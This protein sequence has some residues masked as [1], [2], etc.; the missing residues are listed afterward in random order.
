[1]YKSRR[2]FINKSG[3]II[4]GSGMIS[5]VPMGNVFAGKKI[6]GA[7]DKVTVGLVGCK[8]MGFANLQNFLKQEGV[9]CAALCDVDQNVLDQRASE[10]EKK[11]KQ[12][13]VK[14]NDYRKVIDDK[15]IDVVIVGTPDHWH[16][17]P[18][19][20]A[21]EAGKDVYCEKPLANTIQELDIMVKAVR[22]YDRIVQ[23]GQWQR[24]GPH[25]RAAMDFVFSGQL[26]NIRTVKTWAYQGMDEA[27]SRC[28][29][30]AC[31]GWCRL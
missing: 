11:F 7:N 10:V 27:S 25:W 16:C 8:G 21:C 31:T 17:L 5:A 4:A 14:Y 23:V 12:K 30:W 20:E 2:K 9:E 15:D 1:M 13:P 18:T 19:V 3:K 6:M 28:S 22:K 26:G 29:R 24:S